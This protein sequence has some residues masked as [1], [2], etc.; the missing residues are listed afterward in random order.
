MDNKVA[1]VA[2]VEVEPST[3]D[4]GGRVAA[5][6]DDGYDPQTQALLHDR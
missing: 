5:A 3:A 4:Q 6:D 1:K 2:K